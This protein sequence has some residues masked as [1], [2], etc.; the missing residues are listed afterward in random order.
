MSSSGAPW[1][2]IAPIWRRLGPAWAPGPVTLYCGFDPTGDS[3]HVGHL[4]GQLTLRRFQLRGH[5]PI[6]LAGGATGMIGDPSGKSAERNLLSREQLAHNLTTIK[7]QLSRI[8]DFD[9]KA[10]PARMVDNADWTAGLG[11]LDFLRDVGKYF[12]INVMIGKDSVRSRMEA[13]GGISYTE[14]TLH[15]SS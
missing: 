5:R 4:I 3:L 9:A 2:P 7:G 8:L 6:A 1:S 13:E 14:F 11:Y 12:S 10:N 15:A